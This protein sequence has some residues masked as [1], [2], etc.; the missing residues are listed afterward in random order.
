VNL[1][2]VADNVLDHI[3]IA[4]PKIEPVLEQYSKL[5]GAEITLPK[6]VSEQGIRMAYIHFQN[7]KIELIEPLND[8]SPIAKFLERNPKGAMHHFCAVTTDAEESSKKIKNNKMRA[9]GEPSEGHHGQKMFF[10][11]PSDTSSILVEIVENKNG[12]GIKYEN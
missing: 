12:K 2:K 6:I 10:M 5:F 3:A 1:E 7:V 4:V 11:H 9:L 8:Q